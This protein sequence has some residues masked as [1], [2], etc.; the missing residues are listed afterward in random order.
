MQAAHG[1]A[2][3]SDGEDDLISDREGN[4]VEEISAQQGGGHEGHRK[5]DVANARDMGAIF[6]WNGFCKKCIEAYAQRRE[7][8]CHEEGNGDD[9]INL[10]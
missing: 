1:C 9:G 2:K 7:R 3:K 8:D 6:I 5:G 10:G 4:M